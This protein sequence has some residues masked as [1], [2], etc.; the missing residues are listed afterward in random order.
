MLK[1]EIFPGITLYQEQTRKMRIVQP[2]AITINAYARGAKRGKI[3]KPDG[4]T[5]GFHNEERIR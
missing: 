2:S 1:Y 4:F 5:P 3:G